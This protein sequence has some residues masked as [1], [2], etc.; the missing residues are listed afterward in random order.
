M[1][2]PKWA[3][4]GAI[5]EG[6]TREELAAPGYKRSA[7]LMGHEGKP[8]TGLIVIGLRMGA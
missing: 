5:V 8:T 3:Q 1:Q 4:G 6:C 2:A 7:N